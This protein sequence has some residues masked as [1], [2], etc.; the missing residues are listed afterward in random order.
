MHLSQ[1]N[2]FIN[3]TTQ[4]TGTFSAHEHAQRMRDGAAALA[5]A[6]KASAGKR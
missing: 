1:H 4:A 2:V 5:A 3:V 6:K